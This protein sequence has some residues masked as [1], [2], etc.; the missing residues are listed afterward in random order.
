MRVLPAGPVARQI[1]GIV[2]VTASL[3][4][5]AVKGQSSFLESNL[6]FT[7]MMLRTRKEKLLQTISGLPSAELCKACPHSRLPPLDFQALR[8]ID[9][10]FC[11]ALRP[12]RITEKYPVV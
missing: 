12:F 8:F 3:L 7:S 5:L 4:A 11:D 2:Y 6:P 9:D 1:A 10:A